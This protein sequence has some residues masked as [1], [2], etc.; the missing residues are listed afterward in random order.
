MLKGKFAASLAVLAFLATP[1]QGQDR[2]ITFR[3]LS[4]GYSHTVNLNGSGAD[5]HFKLGYLIGVG[6]GVQINNY[7]AILADGSISRTKGTG[8][9]AF[10]NEIV[11]RYFVGGRVELR[12]PFGELAPFV[13]GGAGA[14]VVDQQGQE[15]TEDFDHFTR[16]AAEFGAGLSFDIPRTPLSVLAEGRTMAYRWVAQPYSRQQWDIAYTLGFSYRLGI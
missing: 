9:V 11:N 2:A 12:Y 7:V 4:G 8:A 15:S 14:M 16:A 3:A 10:A 1:L 13:F 6:A 5:A